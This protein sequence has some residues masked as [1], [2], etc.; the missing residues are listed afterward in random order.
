MPH[1]S[2][3]I[4][5]NEQPDPSESS[6]VSELLCH[7]ARL[8]MVTGFLPNILLEKRKKSKKE[9]IFPVSWRSVVIRRGSW[10]LVLPT[11]S[12]WG[13]SADLTSKVAN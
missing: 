1:K 2:R 10:D 4:I 5:A 9:W 6:R 7:K 8:Q 11:A 3:I 12:F 13:E